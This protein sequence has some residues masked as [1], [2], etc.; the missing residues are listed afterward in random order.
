MHDRYDREK[1]G[2]RSMEDL[3]E[4]FYAITAELALLKVCA[5]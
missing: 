2:L 3:K 4:R 1:Y 5:W